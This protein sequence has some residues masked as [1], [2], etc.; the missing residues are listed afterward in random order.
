VS[1][2]IHGSGAGEVQI[3]LTAII[4]QI[5]TFSAHGRRKRFAEGAPQ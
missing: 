2:E 4:P 1:D 5:D 3:A